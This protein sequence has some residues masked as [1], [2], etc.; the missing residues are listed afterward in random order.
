MIL[1][2]LSLRLFGRLLTLG[3]LGRTPRLGA[4][5]LLPMTSETQLTRTNL[6]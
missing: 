4:S 6:T 3:G 1:H 2:Y 5:V